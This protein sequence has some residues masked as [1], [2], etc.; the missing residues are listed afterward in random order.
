[1]SKITWFVKKT[2]EDVYTPS[3]DYYYGSINGNNTTSIYIQVWNNYQGTTAQNDMKNAKLVIKTLNLDDSYLFD[4]ISI[5]VDNITKTLVKYS[6]IKY[7]V[8]IGTLSGAI[9]NGSES[10]QANLVTK[11]MC[12]I[13]LIIN[14]VNH[15][16]KDD[17]KNL[18]LNI[19]SE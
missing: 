3:N 10:A 11:N 14:G 5:R 12:N 4:H 17:I 16:V 1:M 7:G 18:I 6:D 9:N 19:E 2:I 8:T 13:E 15:K